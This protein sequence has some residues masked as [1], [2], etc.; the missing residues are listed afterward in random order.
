MERGGEKTASEGIKYM[1]EKKDS[2]GESV[3]FGRLTL[4]RLY[5]RRK[6]T[7]SR[8]KKKRRG[9]DIKDT[10]LKKK[11]KRGERG[12]EEDTSFVVSL[13]ERG[14]FSIGQK[15]RHKGK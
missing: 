6:G 10:P 12:M 4:T 9:R 15:K 8:Q 3:S 11:G 5:R 13:V 2:K 1:T 7:T 14:A